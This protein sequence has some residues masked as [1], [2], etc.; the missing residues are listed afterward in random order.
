MPISMTWGDETQTLLWCKFEGQWTWDDFYRSVAVG[1][2]MVGSVRH[3]VN[4]VAHTLNT[5]KLP[6]A[7]RFSDLE[8]ALVHS[9]FNIG[10]VIVITRK[11][12][13]KRLFAVARKFYD[14]ENRM[15]IVPTVKE[16]SQI[17]HEYAGRENK[18][19]K[20]LKA[21][22]SDRLADVTAALETLRAHDW[23]Y[24][25]TL[26][27]I[28]LRGHYLEDAN[29]FLAD[30]RGGRFDN[31]SMGRA[32][33]FKADLES[34]DF[35]RTNLQATSIGDANLRNVNFYQANLARANLSGSDLR[36]ANLCGANL[37]GAMIDNVLLFGSY[38]D[39]QT[40]LPD[41]RPWRSHE[42]VEYFLKYSA[43]RTDGLDDIDRLLSLAKA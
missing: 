36:D 5:A 10:I 7:V 4:I 17:L 2:R 11:I 19:H 14:L 23:L 43:L 26:Q 38:F 42:D 29:F 30:M 18:K 21:L 15:F 3:T 6:G 9:P 31:A 39:H 33:F 35:V 13:V 27:G 28:D 37:E 24:D 8:R 40:I 32:N 16:A 25:G 12:L 22:K 41:G 34:A 20:A 1:Q